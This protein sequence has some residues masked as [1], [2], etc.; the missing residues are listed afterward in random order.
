MSL[1]FSDFKS[2]TTMCARECVIVKGTFAFSRTTCEV[3]PKAQKTGS[4]SSFNVVNPCP[5]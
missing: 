1:N 4:S 5:P 3:A 2:V